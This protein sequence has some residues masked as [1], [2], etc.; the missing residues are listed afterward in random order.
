M[1]I[2]CKII[3]ERKN[4]EGLHEL[5]F[6]D[7]LLQNYDSEDKVVIIQVRGM[8]VFVPGLAGHTKALLT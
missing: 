5:P 1:D 8:V 6:I 3:H 2:V 4:G 7:S